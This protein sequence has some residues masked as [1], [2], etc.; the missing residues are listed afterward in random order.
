EG[1]LGEPEGSDTA[2]ADEEEA[3]AS[4]EEME[5]RLERQPALSLFGWITAGASVLVFGLYSLLTFQ[6]L[7]LFKL[8]LTSFFPLA[9]LILAV[10]GS[11]I[12]GFATPAEAAAMGAFGGI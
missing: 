4:Q 12:F 7:E 2:F 6:R 8:M 9:I 5:A 11:I 10:L 3:A 1:G